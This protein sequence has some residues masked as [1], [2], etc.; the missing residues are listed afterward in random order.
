VWLPTAADSKPTTKQLWELAC[1]R[2]KHFG[3]SV[4]PK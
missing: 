4:T 1:L 3:V 2:C